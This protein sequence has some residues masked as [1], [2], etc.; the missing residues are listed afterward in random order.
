MIDTARVRMG[1]AAGAHSAHAP[2]IAEHGSLSHAPLGSR[3]RPVQL[4]RPPPRRTRPRRIALSLTRWPA[5]PSRRL[6][7]SKSISLSLSL[8][9]FSSLFLSITH[10]QTHTHTYTYMHTSLS[11]AAPTSLVKIDGDGDDIIAPH[12]NHNEDEIVTQ[13]TPGQREHNDN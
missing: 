7:I 5:R 9:L 1:H 11:A 13:N 2:H 12:G 8:S 4:S 10:T 6:H 3:L